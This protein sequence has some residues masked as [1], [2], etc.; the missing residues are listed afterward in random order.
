MSESVSGTGSR[1]GVLRRIVKRVLRRQ[2]TELSVKVNEQARVSANDHPL[3]QDGTRADGRCTVRLRFVETEARGDQAV[4][5]YVADDNDPAVITGEALSRE[6]RVYRPLGGG[7]PDLITLWG[8]KNFGWNH[9]G[10]LLRHKHHNGPP[11]QLSDHQRQALRLLF[12]RLGI[13]DGE[14][15]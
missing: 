8:I 15:P 13:T 2:S 11:P 10:K 3:G 12:K 6:L 14:I 4:D 7:A 5:L 9:R 1:L